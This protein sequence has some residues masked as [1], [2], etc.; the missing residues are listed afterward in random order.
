MSKNRAPR[1][2]PLQTPGNV[3]T[4]MA[5]VY[6]L[7]R[8]GDIETQDMGRFIQALNILVGVIRD[9]DIEERLKKLEQAHAKR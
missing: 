9:T 7:G 3:R 1:I 5:R 2:G 4:E 8:Q 6:R